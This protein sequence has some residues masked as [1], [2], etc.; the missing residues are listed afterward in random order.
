MQYKITDLF[1]NT[2]IKNVT[3]L[4]TGT[5]GSQAVTIFCIPFVIKLYGSE[6]FGAF[7]SF[8]AFAALLLP[9]MTFSYSFAIN[10]AKNNSEAIK[11]TFLSI[12]IAILFA[13]TIYFLLS[14]F[15]QSFSGYSQFK[16]LVF[17]P[18]LL[19]SSA[20][21]EIFQQWIVRRK[22]LTAFASSMIFTSVILNALKILFAFLSPTLFP[23]IFIAIITGPFQLL[24]YLFFG[25]KL[26]SSFR[27]GEFKFYSLIDLSKKYRNFPKYRMPQLIIFS[28][29]QNLPVILI[30]S[31][32]NLKFAAY[33]SLARMAMAVPSGF[34]GKSIGDIFYHRVN[35]DAYN[36]QDIYL[37]IRKV[38]IFIAVASL[39]PFVLIFIFG[40]W[41]FKFILGSEWE[42][43]GECAR[44]L[45]I[46]YYVNL[47][48]KPSFVSAPILNLQKDLLINEFA[49]TIIQ[50]LVLFACI[51]LLKNL[52]VGIFLFSSVGTIF[53]IFF[54]FKTMTKAKHVKNIN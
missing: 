40:P 20:I 51:F 14:F 50:L 18:I 33:Y 27:F 13:T 12:L 2:F 44:W 3:L 37:L 7:S 38:T 31:L 26:I 45:S 47:I 42:V 48:K 16:D 35:E 4:V 43:S 11:I 34:L 5:F 22:M 36:N 17:L 30:A 39:I 23:L 19:L 41:I 49:S 52:M 10:L 28:V 1:K 53:Y 15:R 25:G 8:T 6:I 54:I 29:S 46:F 9:L 21:F 24:A 32:I